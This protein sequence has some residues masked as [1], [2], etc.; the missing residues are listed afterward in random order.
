[1]I[2]LLIAAGSFIGAVAA[3]RGARHGG[4][5]REATDEVRD[6]VSNAHDSN[7]R[8]D[9]DRVDARVEQVDTKVDRL[10]GSFEAFTRSVE[11]FMRESREA[12]A[13]QDRIAVT[14]HPEGT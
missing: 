2:W 4:A 10:T 3:V 11:A 6:R 12:A 9:V 1:M 13:R 5:T 14:H 8:D 7:L